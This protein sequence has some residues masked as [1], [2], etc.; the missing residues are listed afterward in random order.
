MYFKSNPMEARKISSRDFTDTALRLSSFSVMAPN[1]YNSGD[2]K[3]KRYIIGRSDNSESDTLLGL[4]FAGS[5]TSSERRQAN[6]ATACTTMTSGRGVE[7]SPM[8]LCL[9]FN[10]HVGNND[11]CKEVKGAS[12]SPLAQEKRRPDIDL[13]LSLSTGAAE[14][15]ITS[16]TLA[17]SPVQSSMEILAASGVVQ[18]VDEGSTSSKWKHGPLVPPLHGLQDTSVSLDCNSNH[19]SP[20]LAIP[21]RTISTV[22]QP[23]S[24]GCAVASRPNQQHKTNV[25][26]CQF[27]GCYKG[28]R[29]ASGF[30]ISHGGGRRCQKDGC[31]KG[32]EGK[33]VFCKAHGGG[34]RCEN[35]GCT[36]SA[37]GRTNFCIAHGGGKRCSYPQ[38][39]ARA[40]RGKSGLCIRHG[41]GKRCKMENCTKSAEGFSGLCIAHGG[42]RR[43]EYP[44]CTKGAQG[45]TKFC[46]AHGGGKRCTF[47]MCTKGAEGSTPFCKGHGGG[48][49]CSFQ[50]GS[51]CTK[52]VHGGTLFCVAHGGGKRCAA[53]DCT[54]SAR[55]RTNFCVRHGGG[56][57]C[58]FEG[59]GKSAQGSTDFCKAHGGGKRCLWGQAN[60]EFG[61]DGS[62]PC[63]KFA[64]GKIGLC[65]AHSAQ[66][67]DKRVHGHA[68]VG[69]LL[70]DK[71][72][73]HDAYSQMK[74]IA[75]A[76]IPLDGMKNL[77]GKGSSTGGNHSYFG[78]FNYTVPSDLVTRSTLL[79]AEGSLPEGRVHGG[80]LIAMMQGHLGFGS[81]GG[82]QVAGSRS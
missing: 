62:D 68:T 39:C 25:K 19:A 31:Q 45:S 58:K 65:A 78:G 21:I 7:E 38:G 30:C 23:V 28:A 82:G 60:S 66:L 24:S 18:L 76:N 3:R 43:C 79:P 51:V 2:N 42:G 72:H 61:G 50:G 17:S 44:S 55:G 14:S 74:E 11:L 81:G 80:G 10:I 12:L 15:E 69:P 54:R 75:P 9:D 6:S 67:H 59:C 13:G 20:I 49:R 57:R 48:K 73:K 40:A 5:G 71:K 63:D 36:K 77:S 22:A 37:E 41:G 35:L 27:P 29:G 46:K 16:I 4:G 32:A 52:S 64:R 56:K 1:P 47:P 34:R 26:T 8:N 70:R 53:L 33:T